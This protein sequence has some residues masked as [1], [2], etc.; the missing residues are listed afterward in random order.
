MSDQ[1]AGLFIFRRIFMIG[2][3]GLALLICLAMTC[4]FAIVL[5]VGV[6]AIIKIWKEDQWR[7]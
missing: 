6:G 7:Q 4:L 5:I 1:E 2:A 3:K